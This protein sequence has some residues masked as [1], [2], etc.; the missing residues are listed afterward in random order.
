M[1]EE[2]TAAVEAT[3]REIR[4]KTRKKY[5]AEEKVRIVLEGLRGEE[6]IA[7]LCRREGIHQNM[8]YKWSKECT[9]SE[10]LGQMGRLGKV[11][12]PG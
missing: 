10:D 12:F 4:R 2:T 6:K 9:S 3:V 5:S 1:S 11:W 8:Y 7:E